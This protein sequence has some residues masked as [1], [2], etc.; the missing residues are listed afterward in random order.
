MGEDSTCG[1][2]L[3]GGELC[4]RVLGGRAWCGS[5]IE[6]FMLGGVLSCSRVFAGVWPSHCPPSLIPGLCASGLTG[7]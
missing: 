3:P 1:R 6:A 5:R 4:L 2:A 7:P